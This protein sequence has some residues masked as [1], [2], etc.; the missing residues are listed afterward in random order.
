MRKRD[1][2]QARE[3]DNLFVPRVCE[4]FLSSKEIELILR[5]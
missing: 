3:N 5:S 4:M 2:G 1:C